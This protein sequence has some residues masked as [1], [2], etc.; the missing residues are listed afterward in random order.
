MKHAIDSPF[1]EAKIFEI[2]IE[3]AEPMLG[4][5]WRVALYLPVSFLARRKL[6]PPVRASRL[7]GRITKAGVLFY[8]LM[9]VILFAAF[10]QGHLAPDFPFWSIHR[11]RFRA[12]C[13]RYCAH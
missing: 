12:R 9:V 6:R 3:F 4:N 10:A 1:P 2:F 8:R 7:T 11:R 13:I 5:E